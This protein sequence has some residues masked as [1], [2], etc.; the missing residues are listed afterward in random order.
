[1]P[2]PMSLAVT[3]DATCDVRFATVT[4]P[5]FPVHSGI[6][7]V[8]VKDVWPV[9]GLL[10]PLSPITDDIARSISAAVCWD[11]KL[12]RKEALRPH[13]KSGS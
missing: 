13:Q 5:A 6:V 3:P 8:F 11:I 7:Q 9:A 4:K 10:P 2:R 1:L 12:I